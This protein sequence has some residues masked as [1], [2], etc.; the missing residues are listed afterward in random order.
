MSSSMK[1]IAGTST[2]SKMTKASC[3]SNRA[4]GR[5]NVRL[6]RRCAVTAQEDQ[7]RSVHRYR[8]ADGVRRSGVGGQRMAWVTAISSANG[9]RVARMRRAPRCHLLPATLCSG[10]GLAANDRSFTRSTVGCTI[11][12]QAV[13]SRASCFWNDARFATLSTLLPSGPSHA[14]RSPAKPANVTFM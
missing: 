7:P 1:M 13:S 11:V 10:T 6:G 4:D 3:S 12:R 8:E 14:V 2:S 9:A 5:S